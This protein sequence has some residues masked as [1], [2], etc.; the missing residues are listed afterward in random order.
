MT[1]PF[2]FDAEPLQER[3]CT[4]LQQSLDYAMQQGATAAE[5]S[6]GRSKGVAVTARMGE[7]EMIEYEDDQGFDITVYFG[8][9]KG[10]A[11]S[12]DTQPDSIKKSV[13][14]ACEVAKYICED[15]YA[16]LAD[17][18]LFLQQEKDLNL[19]HPWRVD[20]E[21]MMAMAIECENAARAVPQISNSEGA[22]VKTARSIGAYGNTSGFLAA[23]TGT[24]HHIDCGAIASQGDE[25]QRDMWFNARRDANDLQTP[26]AIG[27][28]AALRAVQRLGSRKIKS[29]KVPVIFSPQTARS[30]IGHFFTAVN[31][32]SLYRGMSFLMDSLGTQVFPEWLNIE[33]QPHIPKGLYSSAFDSEGV[34]TEP[35][36]I[37]KN[38][39]LQNYILDSYSARKLGL[40]ST[41]NADGV[42]NPIISGED[43]PLDDLL[44]KMDRGLIVNELIGQG[45]NPISGDYSQG[46][47]GFWVENGKI[48][49][50][51]EE[52]TLAGNLK[53]MFMSI[54]A[55]GQ[56][57][58]EERNIRCGSILVD[59]MMVA[60][61]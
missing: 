32:A 23:V 12:S 61:I 40:T 51:V 44:A 53:E 17:R 2:D 43:M 60:G 9:K 3:L 31:G 7:A 1:K 8:T 19:D 22:S 49:H 47:A 37:V 21:T 26:K 5:S 38:G 48:V 50:P 52:I 39:E 45:T 42:K 35:R 20:V 13:E 18:D 36:T 25:M 4:T 56:D 14:A 34:A 58:D 27:E 24:V 54:S 16:G 29:G 28:R 46:A 57:L 15:E 11:S 41:G 10:N 55:V 59:S 33:E 6:I 30:I